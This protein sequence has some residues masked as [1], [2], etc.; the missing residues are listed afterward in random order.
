MALAC[1]WWNKQIRLKKRF[2]FTTGYEINNAIKKHSQ[3][4]TTKKDANV[5]VQMAPTLN[6][7]KEGKKGKKKKTTIY[8][9]G[10][11]LLQ[12]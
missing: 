8:A 3:I 9:I 12:P 5:V 10:Q 2:S 6:L 4:E 7:S 1:N 11:E